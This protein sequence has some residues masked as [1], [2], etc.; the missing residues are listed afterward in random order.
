MTERT[1]VASS[2]YSIF[3]LPCE[4]TCGEFFQTVVKATFVRLFPEIKFFDDV[5]GWPEISE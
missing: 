3:I 2:S 5:S 4:K 1:T